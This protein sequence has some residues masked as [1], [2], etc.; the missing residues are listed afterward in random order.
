MAEWKSN[1]SFSKN[2][3]QEKTQIPAV[4]TAEATIESLHPSFPIRL[5]NWMIV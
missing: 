5:T 1:M 3:G 4:S 2:H